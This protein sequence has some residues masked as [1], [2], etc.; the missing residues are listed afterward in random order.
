MDQ[1]QLFVE[2]DCHSHAIVVD[3][4]KDDAYGEDE[5]CLAFFE[6]GYDGRILSFKDRLRWC[7]H[8]LRHGNPWTDSVILDRHKA[9]RLGEFLS[10]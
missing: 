8:I 10:K 3:K 4:I 9:K 5:Y 2:C 6:R 7:W 1:N